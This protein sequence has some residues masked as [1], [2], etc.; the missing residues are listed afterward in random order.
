MART[1]KSDLGRMPILHYAAA[2]WQRQTP[3]IRLL[4]G[5]IIPEVVRILLSV[6]AFVL[7]VAILPAQQRQPFKVGVDLVNFGVAV[8]DKQV[9]R[10]TGRK[11]GEFRNVA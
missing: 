7:S 1:R 9:K 11:E 3:S 2:A 5:G 4:D 6:S 10:V 8:V